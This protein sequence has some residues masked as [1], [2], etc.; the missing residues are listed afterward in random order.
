MTLD[1][2]NIK[3]I[4]ALASGAW[5]SGTGLAEQL[6]ISREAVSKRLQKLPQWGLQI[7]TQAG[8]GYRLRPALELL[9]EA[10][11]RS[12][13]ANADGDASCNLHIINSTASSNQWLAENAT[14]LSACLAEHQSAG[15]G[16][17]GRDWF[18][19]F[20]QNL[21]LSLRCDLPAWPE[22]LSALGLVLGVAL[23]ERFQQAAIP[24]QLKWPNDLYLNGK[25]CGGMLIEQRG[26]AHGPC[27]LI[28][29]L[30]LNVHMRDAQ[31]DQDW[32]SLS[33]QGHNVSRNQWATTL[34][35]TL[36][37]EVHTISDIHIAAQLKK[38]KHYD[39]YHGQ[40]VRLSNNQDS[41][42]GISMGIDEWGRLL[43]KTND[44]ITP[45]SVGD[46]SLR[47]AT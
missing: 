9:N 33:V 36:L 3:L 11:I 34:I 26:E 25:K 28:I 19:P 27:S 8:R 5:I 12:Q 20:G 4:H 7:D 16:R 17:R 31:I 47:P 43:L 10:Q 38:F 2:L 29:G 41:H 42:D 13:L 40:P 44:G 39:L 46:V 37:A 30:G 21:Y 45:F 15:R 35:Q 6:H 14:G 32:T 23:C 18:S 1:S 24:L 22:K